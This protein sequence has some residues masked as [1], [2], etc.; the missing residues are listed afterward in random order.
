MI[1]LLLTDRPRDTGGRTGNSTWSRLA[2]AAE[3][4]A[5]VGILTFID[6]M[7]KE[8]IGRYAERIQV[9]DTGQ[10]PSIKLSPVCVQEKNYRYS[11][12]LC[13]WN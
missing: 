8:C 7:I 5:D 1:I 11:V 3:G 9:T 4:R 13:G 12:V 6:E 10:F 2:P